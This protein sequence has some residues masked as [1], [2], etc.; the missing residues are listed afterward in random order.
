M[1][2]EATIHWVTQALTGFAT[3]PDT[4]EQIYIPVP[5]CMAAGITPNSVGDDIEVKV[6][7]NTA[8]NYEDQTPWRALRVSVIDRG[9][10]PAPEPEPEPETEPID[11]TEEEV[12]AY[13]REET[14]M[15]FDFVT[16]IAKRDLAS[17]TDRPDLDELRATYPQLDFVFDLLEDKLAE[18]ESIETEH[19]KEMSDLCENYGGSISDLEDRVMEL[20]EALEDI[21][22]RS[23]DRVAVALSAAVL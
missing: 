20:R 12:M 21:N 7:R 23:T 5:I 4:G 3:R 15:P 19:R 14:T 8:S 1:I 11:L 22:E 18:V 6:V 13:F 2:T 10:T 17:G 16:A 9:E